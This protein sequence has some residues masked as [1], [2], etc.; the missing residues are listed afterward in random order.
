MP[1]NNVVWTEWVKYTE[2]LKL[3]ASDMDKNGLKDKILES[4][5]PMSDEQKNIPKGYEGR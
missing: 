1:I 4:M 2:Q 5:G 3:E